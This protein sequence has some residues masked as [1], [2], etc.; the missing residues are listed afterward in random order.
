MSQARIRVL[1]VEDDAASVSAL[2]ALL[3]ASQYQ[4]VGS[5]GSGR[6]AIRLAESSRPDLVIMDIVLQGDLDG[7]QTADLIRERFDIPVLYLTG[8]ADEALFERARVTAPFAYLTKPC[9]ERDL[10]RAIAVALDRHALLQRIKASEAHLAEAQRVAHVGSWSWELARDHVEASDEMLRLF[11]L[12]RGTFEPCLERFLLCVEA[13]DRPVMMQ[14][15]ESL[16]RGE[17]P[18]DIDVRVPRVDGLRVLRLRGGAHIDADGKAFELLGTARDVTAE[19]CARQ[20]AETTRAELETRVAERTA[21]LRAANARMQAEIDERLRME[22]TLWTSQERYRGLIDNLPDPVLVRQDEQIVFANP[23]AARL[24]SVLAPTALLGAP[25]AALVHP[26]FLAVCEQC[27]QA[28]LSGQSSTTPIALKIRRSDGRSVD[29]ES[30]AFAFSFEGRPSVLAVLHDMTFRRQMER[31]AERFRVA[32]DSLPD[33]VFLTDPVTM[34]FID[35]NETALSSLGYSRAELLAL[36]PHDIKPRFNKAMLRQHY[37]AVVAGLPD[38]EILQTTHRRKDGSTFPV[39]VRLRPFTS[40]GQ[41]LLISVVSDIS[42]RQLAESRLHEA[43][44]R[45]QQLAASVSEVFWIHDLADNTFLYVSPAYQTLFGKPVASLYRHPRSFLSRVHPEDHDRVAAAFEGQRLNPQ[46]VELEYRIVLANNAVRWIW[47]RTFPICNSEGKVYRMAGVAEDVTARRASEEQLRNIIQT[48]MDGFWVNDAQGRLLD[49]N[50]ASCRTLGYTREEMLGLSLSD[51][52]ALESPAET[53]AHV[54]HIIENGR[55]RFESR[56]RRKS[57]ELLDVEISVYYQ[58]DAGGGHFH[59]F[60]RDI[61]ERKRAEAALRESE[62]RFRLLFEYAPIGIALA[63]SDRHFIQVNQTLCDMLGY[64]EAELVGKSFIDITHPED[65]EP[66][67][68]LFDQ[69]QS[70]EISGYR[71]AKRYL[72]RNG[73][74]VWASLTSNVIRDPS[75]APLYSVGMIENIT[76]RV[77]AESARLQHEASLREALVREVH[78]RIK[79]NLHG[80]IGLL[81]QHIVDHSDMQAPIEAAINQINAISVVYGLQSRLPQKELCLRELLPEIGNAATALALLPKLAPIEDVLRGNVWLD[82]NASVSIALVLNELIQNAL[83]HGVQRNIAEVSIHLAGDGRRAVIRICNPGAGLPPDF[84]FAAGRGHGTGLGL[85]RT[86]LPRHGA[87]LDI[88][89]DGVQVCAE[90]VLSPPVIT[91]LDAGSAR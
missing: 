56:H 37:A 80:V 21:D 2:E 44:E 89:Y 81:R 39:E 14:A 50:E 91:E 76:E 46:G 22:A 23:A 72:H 63:G 51:I 6:E 18:G 87:S 83:K 90:L 4:H 78:H 40:E 60:V 47:V 73:G 36:G 35:V 61:G 53:A 43:N 66:N 41:P 84:D 26:D 7:I 85:V 48:S 49:C 28:A 57:G 13:E 31:A 65:M 75:G 58:P 38:T 15:I 10:K 5:V 70:G 86:L 64:S 34:R 8:Y 16:L 79:N 24:F 20:E 29:V 1:I 17:D 27:Q 77:N 55:D 12:E 30:L 71:L 74:V 3:H 33:A 88:R 69:A 82:S 67:L 68:E 19:V 52:E 42:E 9:D 25:L 32:L 59:A 54:R 11:C 62:M 45:F